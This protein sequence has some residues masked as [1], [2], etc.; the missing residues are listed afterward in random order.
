MQTYSLGSARLC[1]TVSVN[2]SQV[3]LLRKEEVKSGAVETCIFFQAVDARRIDQCEWNYTRNFG[4]DV[5]L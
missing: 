5:S 2:C 1:Q 4:V 3:Q